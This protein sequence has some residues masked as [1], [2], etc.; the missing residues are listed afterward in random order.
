MDDIITKQKKPKDLGFINP[1]KVEIYI[2]KRVIQEKNIK[3][4]PVPGA[5]EVSGE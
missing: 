4:N 2:N 3:L 1:E 5:H